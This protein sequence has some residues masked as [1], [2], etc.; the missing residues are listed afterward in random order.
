P[1]ALPVPEISKP[2]AS[3]TL[4]KVPSRWR[5]G[6]TL[7][8]VLVGLASAAWLWPS[9]DSRLK[10]ALDS[11]VRFTAPGVQRLPLAEPGIYTIFCDRPY[12]TYLNENGVYETLTQRPDLE[13]QLTDPDG[14]TVPLKQED[15]HPYYWPGN[16]T[17]TA[18][19]SFTVTQPGTYELTTSY[20]K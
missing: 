12:S 5:D 15:W 19:V 10:R 3:R 6:R 8:L 11:L 14:A 17:A 4:R 20:Q 7:I 1:D 9:Q 18:I 2:G 13:Y 16:R